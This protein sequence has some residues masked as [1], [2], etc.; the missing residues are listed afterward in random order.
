MPRI[1][2][3]MAADTW[4]RLTRPDIEERLHGLGDVTMCLDAGALPETEYAALWARADFALTGWG[5]RAPTADM[6]TAAAR[7]RAICHGAGSVRMIPRAAMERGIVVTSARAAIA[8]TVAEYSLMGALVMLR[9]LLCFASGDERVRTAYAPEGGRPAN[10][11]LFGKTV[12]LV[13]YGCV[14]RHMRALL[15][16]FGG[17]VLAH[18]PFLSAEEAEREEVETRSLDELL[19]AADVVSLHAPD[20]PE[21]RGMIGA[22]ELGLLRG[23]AVLVNSARGRLIDTQALTQALDGGR[24]YAVLDVTDPEPLPPDHPLRSMP[25]VLLTPHTAGP[26]T[27]DL[28]EL[29]RSAIGELERLAR[30]EP[31][32]YPI[33]L[34]AYDR[35]SF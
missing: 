4:R 8:R 27:D 9:R 11:T 28:P 10:A 24:F 20:V 13:G 6:L 2:C 35:M 16:P 5:V 17:R 19:A 31:P 15:H 14:G 22:R 26:T 3:T 18:D 30:G 23:G 12:G 29:M 32:R 33:D 34:P 7:L 25:N 21:T 1:L